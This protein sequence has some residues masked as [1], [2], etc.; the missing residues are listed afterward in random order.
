MTIT[1]SMLF[2]LVLLLVAA[3]AVLALAC[4]DEEEDGG[5][6]GTPEATT[7]GGGEGGD[8]SDIPEDTTGITDTEILLGSHMPLSGAAASLY[9]NQIVPG[10]LAYFEYINETEGG[11]N[12]RQIKLL[13]EDDTYD[14][15]QTNTVVRKLV[16]TDQVFAI[17]SGLGTAQHS[18]VFEYLKE[19]KVPDL[20]TATGATLFTEPISRTTFGY[21]PN[22]VQEGEQIGRFITE[23]YP[24]AKLGLI[25][26]NDDFGGD[27]EEGIRLGIEGSDV[28]IVATETYEAVATDM[29]AQ[30]QRLQNEGATV[31]AGYTLPLQAAS[32]MQTARE[33]LSWDAPI[34][35]SGVVADPST[36]AIA[37][38]EN[39]AD[40]FTTGY[41]RPLNQSEDPAIQQ[42]IE[43]MSECDECATKDATNLSLYGQSVAELTVEVLKTAG[44]NLN[45]R[46][47]IE[48]AESIRGFVC[49]ACLGPINLSPT[50]HRA[51]ETFSF[52]QAEV[53]QWVLFGDVISFETTT[54]GAAPE[55]GDEQPTEADG[56]DE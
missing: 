13:V 17:V 26:Q 53:D 18:A 6:G 45:R 11:V 15:S 36:L 32:I 30:V 27:G 39:T 44:E 10:M 20:F 28:E 5:E 4:D 50:D 47:V 37:G 25:L 49:G 56:G 1:K 3:V 46:S 21:N 23:Q 33:Q 24:D 54:D 29:S 41:L 52:A 7:E 14:P 38:A 43:I 31:V 19:N 34:I 42:H 16:E 12:G 48:A 40:V 8:L 2:R 22:Y 9:G 55:G 35:F 51:I